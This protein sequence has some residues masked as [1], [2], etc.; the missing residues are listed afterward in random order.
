MSLN[1]TNYGNSAEQFCY[2]S[3][4]NAHVQCSAMMTSTSL[5]GVLQRFH[6]GSK[7]SPRRFKSCKK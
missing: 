2:A 5:H 1:I 7:I 3:V 6:E 4:I